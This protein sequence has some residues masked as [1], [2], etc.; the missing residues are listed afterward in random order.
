MRVVLKVLA[1]SV[2]NTDINTRTA[3]YSKAVRGDTES[4]ARARGNV[5]AAAAD[6]SWSGAPLQFPLI[7]GADC[8]GEIVA[9]WRRCARRPDRGARSGACA[10][11]DGDR[12]AMRLAP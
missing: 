10:A 9:G 2:N 11:V 4:G 7:Q 3:W 6:G 12:L 5:D 8:C 1:A